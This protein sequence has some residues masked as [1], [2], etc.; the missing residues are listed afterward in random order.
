MHDRLNWDPAVVGEWVNAHKRTAPKAW[1]T[2]AERLHKSKA[3][4]SAWTTLAK[5]G[6]HPMHVFSVVRQAHANATRE[7]QRMPSK[8]E[9]AALVRV[10][11]AAVKLKEAIECS[12]L[13]SDWGSLRMLQQDGHPQ[14]A[15]VV[16]WR[17]LSPDGHG[18]GYPI[19]IVDLLDLVVDLVQQHQDSLPRRSVP[20]RKDGA[21]GILAA[22]AAKTEHARMFVRWLAYRIK[23]D[24]GS[25]HHACVA[26]I[27]NVV[28][29]PS[30]PLDA[31][32]VKLICRDSPPE[33]RRAKG[34]LGHL[35]GTIAPGG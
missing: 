14:V 23:Q 13:P 25:E 29:R 24:A 7:F 9:K 11:K 27:A 3:M 15:V 32:R 19:A 16:G 5:D 17:D 34:E 12:S 10:K 21:P 31:D 6:M 18:F 8:E 35:A 33:F 1:L 2:I 22:D 28:L 30:Q 4:T 20:R 26:Q